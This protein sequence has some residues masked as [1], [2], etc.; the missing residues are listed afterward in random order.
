VQYRKLGSSDL[1]VS[2][3]ALGS[4]LTYSAICPYGLAIPREAITGLS[5][6]EAWL[7]RPRSGERSAAQF[8]W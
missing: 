5:V 3:I 2:E 4:W 1:I 8:Q 7:G 6:G